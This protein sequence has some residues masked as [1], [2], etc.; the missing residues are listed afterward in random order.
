MKTKYLVLL[1]YYSVFIAYIQK[2]NNIFAL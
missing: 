2:N 1:T